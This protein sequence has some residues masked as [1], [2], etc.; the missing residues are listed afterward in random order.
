MIAWLRVMIKWIFTN[1]NRRIVAIAVFLNVV[2]ALIAFFA[3]RTPYLMILTS[4]LSVY[5]VS[6]LTMERYLAL[7]AACISVLQIL[8]L[9]LVEPALVSEPLHNALLLLALTAA[10]TLLMMSM[11]TSIQQQEYFSTVQMDRQIVLRTA[12]NKLLMARGLPNVYA[13]I[14]EAMSELYG[15]C[16]IIFERSAAGDIRDVQRLP[17][18]L[19]IYESAY[20]AARAAFE[21]GRPAGRFMPKARF[22]RS[23]ISR[24]SPAKRCLPWSRSCLRTASGSTRKPGMRSRTSSRRRKALW[25]ARRWRTGSSPSSSKACASASARIF[26]APSRTICAPRSQAS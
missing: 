2:C 21:T 4:L 15:R 10:L 9:L 12:L 5:A 3:L 16:A 8:A 19:I 23:Y 25:S 17:E 22:R 26:C 24:S 20:D 14:L 11:I 13:T 6:V 18:G 1:K 7:G